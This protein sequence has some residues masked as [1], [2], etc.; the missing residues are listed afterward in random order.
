[1]KSKKWSGE[2]L[3][4]NKQYKTKSVRKSKEENPE[5]KTGIT[6]PPFA[7]WRGIK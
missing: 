3:E 5:V 4:A 2:T 6:E 1:M 7:I